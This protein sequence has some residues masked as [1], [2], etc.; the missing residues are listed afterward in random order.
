MSDRIFKLRI[1]LNNLIEDIKTCVWLWNREVWERD[2]DAY[3]CCDGRE[4]G[5]EGVSIREFYTHRL[6]DKP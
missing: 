3:F 1:L 2:L 4:C 6:G 5:C